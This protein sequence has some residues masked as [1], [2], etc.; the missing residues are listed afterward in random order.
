MKKII[1]LLLA[2]MLLGT[3]SAMALDIGQPMQMDV[4][5]SLNKDGLNQ[6]LTMA[7]AYDASDAPSPEMINAAA[8]LVSLISLTAK[9]N[10]NNM[11]MTINLNQKPLAGVQMDVAADGG[12]A[13]TTDVL[14]NFAFVVDGKT[15]SMINSQLSSMVTGSPQQ[16]QKAAENFM[17]KLESVVRREYEA[18]NVTVLNSGSAS[19]NYEGVNFNYVESKIVAPA[20]AME[21]FRKI[22]IDGVDLIFAFA[23]E[24][25]IM[26]PDTQSLAQFRQN[27]MD[28]DVYSNDYGDNVSIK[29]TEYKVQ[30]GAGFKVDYGY[31]VF[32][33]STGYQMY[34]V[35][36]AQM[37]K[38]VD[39]MICY[40][41]RSSYNNPLTI[42]MAA[43]SGSPDAVVMDL[44]MTAG[45]VPEETT[46]SMS[47]MADGAKMSVAGESKPDGM[48]GVNMKLDYYVMNATAPLLTINYHITPFTGEIPAA[49]ITSRQQV[50]LMELANGYVDSSL[51]DA[52]MQ[53]AQ[54]SL[55][56]LLIKAITAAPEQI[57]VLMN[58]VTTMMNQQNNYNY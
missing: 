36:V 53:D 1:A 51:E 57:E 37:G 55:S 40:G 5:L 7:G 38:A 6:L 24:A 31:T 14:P 39:A 21:A 10:E 4:S 32:E 3:T 28:A 34:Y 35:S 23:S 50:N 30:E 12:L 56:S 43:N 46:F 54:N 48:G 9:G 16:I 11:Q 18:M 25:G 45:A 19:Y 26:L 41:G 13:L 20:D 58:E 15:M 44:S 47:M 52:L 27:A 2:V 29:I 22:C 42:M 8:D 33:V 17:A 49:D